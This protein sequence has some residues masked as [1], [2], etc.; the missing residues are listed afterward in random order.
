MAPLLVATFFADVGSSVATQSIF[1]DTNYCAEPVLQSGV[2]PCWPPRISTDKWALDV[3]T[4]TLTAVASTLIYVIVLWLKTPSNIT[5]DTTSIAGVAAIM[6]HPVV[7][8]D[9]STI[10]ANMTHK[11]LALHLKN[12]RY[13]LGNFV[14]DYQESIVPKYGIVPMESE[15]G[16]D[17]RPKRPPIL[18]RIEGS[19]VNKRALLTFFSDWTRGR[20]YLDIFF[21]VFFLG[22]LGFTIAAVV[23]I[24][25]PRRVF[26]YNTREATVGFRVTFTLIGVLVARYWT[27]LF[28]DVQNFAPYRRLHEGPSRARQTINKKG[29]TLPITAIV[30]LARMG[31]AVPAFVACT[32]LLAEFLVVALAGLPY[33]PGQLR[34][35][36]LFCGVAAMV[37]LVLMLVCLVMVVRWRKKLPTLPRRPDSVAA[38][39]TYVAG[40]NM[41][42]DLEGMEGMKQKEKDQRI[43]RLGKRYA[44]GI[45][46]DQDG[47]KRFVVDEYE[48]GYEAVRSHR[49]WV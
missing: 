40:T 6:G 3:M 45:R 14:V 41:A 30:P 15:A 47:R 44:Y 16:P 35:E 13:A 48:T 10:P 22:L 31:Y 43:E 19:I 49:D 32:T 9:F 34:G 11:Q 29:F 27:M 23:N 4:A 18:Q 17:G 21:G 37:I 24:D 25:D 12:K 42:R 33:R 39:M 1:L 8:R 2:N 28:Q 38:V 5:A 7:E 20:F 36:F 46:V 26:V